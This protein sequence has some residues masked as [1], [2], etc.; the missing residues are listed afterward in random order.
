MITNYNP[1]NA[2]MPVA[3]WN[4]EITLD[5]N[6]KIKTNDVP[7]SMEEVQEAIRVLLKPSFFGKRIKKFEIT[8]EGE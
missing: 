6:N 8:M 7:V 1:D 2:V 5:N 4:I 3:K